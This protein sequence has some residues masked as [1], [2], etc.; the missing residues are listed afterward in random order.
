MKT[1]KKAIAL[2]LALTALC[3]LAVGAY[4]APVDEAT[5]DMTRAG[6]VDLYKYDL[7]NGATRS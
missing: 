1:I 6:S 7:T 4:A 5:I 3:S 2:I